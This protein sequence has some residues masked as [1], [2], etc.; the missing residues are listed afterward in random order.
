VLPNIFAALENLKAEVDINRACETNREII[1]N[2]SQRESR[3]LRIE[4]A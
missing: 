1:T 2:F 4:E 3:L